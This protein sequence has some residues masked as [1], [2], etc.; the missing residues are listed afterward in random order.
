LIRSA[1]HWTILAE[2][3]GDVPDFWRLRLHQFSIGIAKAAGILVD[4][5]GGLTRMKNQ[6]A[7]WLFRFESSSLFGQDPWQRG[8]MAIS[9]R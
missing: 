5:S 4:L 9:G 6:V 2:C 8:G 3:L 7:G 1:Q